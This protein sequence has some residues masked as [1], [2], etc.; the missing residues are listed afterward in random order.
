L[1]GK[2]TIF[3]LVSA[4]I[5][6]WYASTLNPGEIVLHFKD[7]AGAVG[8]AGSSG[9]DVVK[10]SLALFTFVIFLLG[11]GLAVFFMAFKEALRSFH[12]WRHRK[13]DEKQE[14]IQTL[15][16]EGR[17]RLFSGNHREARK[18]LGR[19][20]KKSSG[21]KTVSLEMARAE[22]ADGHPSAAEARLKK[23]L[24]ESPDSQEALALLF[25]LYKSRDNLEGQMAA[26]TRRIE[27]NPD[28]L[29]TLVE[30]RNLYKRTSNWGE[31]VRVQEKILHKTLD[32]DV[33]IV[34]RR[35]LSE[36]VLRSA[37]TAS[38]S[39]ALP[40]LQ[41]LTED[42]PE[43]APA[44]AAVGDALAAAND[45]EAAVQA[46]VRGFNASGQPGLL[47]KAE[48]ARIAA[49]QPEPM[50][51]LY[52]KL[53]KKHPEAVLLKARLLLSLDRSEEALEVLEA[54]KTTGDSKINFQLA[55]EALFK[56]SS[57]DEAAK[58]FR[59]AAFGDSR[60]AFISFYCEKC[61]ASFRGW[62]YICPNCKAVDSATMSFFD[63]DRKETNHLPALAATR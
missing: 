63:V 55:G 47:M 20:I 21:E 2:L 50:L 51:K 52:Q 4:L 56:L 45:V 36:L 3:A 41:K 32:R 42:D 43:F 19:A 17:G 49:A 39:K 54:A 46:W 31:A 15:L 59:T 53:G 9:G 58:N 14:K 26:L 13:Q 34:E 25:E 35:E 5:V 10:T 1:A 18:V 27:V 24:S 12:F 29:P 28:H 23:I 57:F 6:S 60:D 11:F 48:A 30:L 33:Q 8:K 62:R 61:R 22:I 38:P 37:G 7:A 16:D 40:V 44:W